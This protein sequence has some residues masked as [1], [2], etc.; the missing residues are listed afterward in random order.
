MVTDEQVRLLRKKRMEGKTQEAA[1]AAAGMS[2]RTARAWATGPLPSQSR[3][4]RAWRTRKDPFEEVWDS[5]VVP[6]LEDDEDDGLQAKAVLEELMRRHPGKHD[7]GQL[8][9]LQRRFRDWRALHGADKEVIFPQ[10]HPPGR[11]GS[12]DFTHMTELK[13]RI[14]GEPFVH[15]L[16]HFVLAYS[17]WHYVELA[18]GETFEALVRGLQ[19]ALYRLGGVP[20]RGRIDNLSA[21]THD[22]RQGKGRRLTTRF[23]KVL[24]HLGLEV[25]RIQP[26]KPHENGVAER[27]HGLLKTALDQALRLRG[28]RDFASVEAYLAFVDEIVEREFNA[29]VA[30]KLEEERRHLRPLPSVRLPDYTKTYVEVR[31]WS[32]ISVQRRVYSVPSRLIGHRVEARLYP[33]VVEVRHKGV[34]VETIPRLR[35][36]DVHRINYRHVAWSLARKPGAFAHYR[37]REDLF[38]TLTFRRAYDSLR[39]RR[40]DRADVEYVRVLHLAASTSE[41]LVE[42]TLEELIASGKAWDY[43]AV[44]AL[45]QPEMPTVPEVHVGVPDLGDY[46]RLLAQEVV[47]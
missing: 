16:F 40:G 36:E 14:A 6:L 2:V 38:P 29:K 27:G 41:V 32:T 28:S 25:S 44:K 13:V 1:A 43:A 35:G 20:E 8:R 30:A 39:Q 23:R 37:Y 22:L 19:N 18:F 26:G 21:A 10:E 5:E 3:S 9:T 4:P 15:L 45:A 46:D 42:R 12:I 33:D 7:E 47:S 17:G 24:E 31:R 11:T 34:V